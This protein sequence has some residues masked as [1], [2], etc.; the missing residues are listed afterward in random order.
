MPAVFGPTA[1]R[2]AARSTS[3]SGPTAN[4]ARDAAAH[5]R[6][7]RIGPVRR[8]RH[9]DLVAC[10]LTARAMIGADHRHARELAVRTGER[11]ERHTAHAGDRLEHLLQLVQTGE[12]PLAVLRGRERMSRQELGQQRG[13]IAASGVV[14]HGA[15]AER[16][17]MRVDGEVQLRQARVVAHGIE[18]ADLGQQ[19]RAARAA[20]AAGIGAAPRAARCRGGHCARAPRPAREY[21]KIRGSRIAT[22]MAPIPRPQ[23]ARA[24]PSAAARRARAR[25]VRMSAVVLVSVAHTSSAGPS[26]G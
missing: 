26:S 25:S 11:A 1:A 13:R 9:D 14:L 8:L 5:R 3:P 22:L 19:R 15:G 24:Q 18:L 7:G 10:Q 20:A 16:I 23:R 2:S 21:S 6:G 4:L 12:E 17:E